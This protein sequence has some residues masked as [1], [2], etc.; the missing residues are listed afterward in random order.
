MSCCNLLGAPDEQP[1]DDFVSDQ[2]HRVPFG[3]NKAADQDAREAFQTIWLEFPKLLGPKGDS[4]EGLP[5]LGSGPD[6]LARNCDFCEGT[7]AE[8]T[9][10]SAHQKIF[11]PHF[12]ALNDRLRLCMGDPSPDYCGNW[13]RHKAAMVDRDGVW[14]KPFGMT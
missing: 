8:N 5:G 2:R 13:A 4:M 3:S 9:Y 14:A 12:K 1:R 11:D 6:R 7:L 10:S